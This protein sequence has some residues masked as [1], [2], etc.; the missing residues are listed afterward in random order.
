MCFSIH[1]D[2]K[3]RSN[4]KL[5]HILLGNNGSCFMLWLLAIGMVLSTDGIMEIGATTGS[6]LGEC[7]L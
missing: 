2:S 3:A 6:M 1:V 5:H 4:S 7:S